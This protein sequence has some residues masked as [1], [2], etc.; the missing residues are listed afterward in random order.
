MIA[1]DTNLIIRLLT[2]DDQT[3]YKSALKIFSKETIFIPDT[4]LLETEWV[5][6]FVYEFEQQKISM[7]LRKLCGLKN[8]QLADAE[9]TARIIDWYDKGLDFADASHL[10]NSQHCKTLKTFDEKFIKKSKKLSNCA[11]EKP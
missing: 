11:V 4:V 2:Q 1:I 5:L 10:A 6:R 7:A 3:Q 9:R 8:I